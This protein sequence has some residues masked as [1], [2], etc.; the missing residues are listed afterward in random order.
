MFVLA[1]NALMTL[2]A[3]HTECDFYISLWSELIAG[4]AEGHFAGEN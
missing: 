4:T 2:N 1:Q 3:G